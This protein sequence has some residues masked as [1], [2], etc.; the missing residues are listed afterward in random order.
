MDTCAEIYLKQVYLQSPFQL[1]SSV[2]RS[3]WPTLLGFIYI[4]TYCVCVHV[5]S[6]TYFHTYSTVV[7]F[8]PCPLGKCQSWET[9]TLTFLFKPRCA[10]KHSC[11]MDFI[12]KGTMSRGVMYLVCSLIE[13]P[14]DHSLDRDFWLKILLYRKDK[15]P[16]WISCQ[17]STDK[18]YTWR[19]GGG[20]KVKMA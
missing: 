1:F 8:E 2:F 19:R 13:T 6:T 11:P 10:G 7:S 18:N 20:E 14:S 17:N 15:L 16:T 3:V 9:R 12:F 5:H 4:C